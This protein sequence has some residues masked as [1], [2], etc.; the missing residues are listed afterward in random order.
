MPIK[1]LRMNDGYTTKQFFA[2]Q[3]VINSQFLK[4]CKIGHFD[5]PG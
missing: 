1:H 2:K 3:N 5:M 4:L